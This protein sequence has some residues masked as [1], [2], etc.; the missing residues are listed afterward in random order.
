MLTII[1]HRTLASKLRRLPS[2]SRRRL[3]MSILQR[4]GRGYLRSPRPGGISRLRR[5]PPRLARRG[6]ACCCSLLRL[7]SWLWLCGK[8]SQ[9]TDSM[10][11]VCQIPTRLWT[12]PLSSGG[13]SS[14]ASFASS[15]AVMRASF[16]ATDSPLSVI[17]RYL[18]RADILSVK[19]VYR[20][21]WLWFWLI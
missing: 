13:L 1:F 20:L 19:K 15:C 2:V 5:L 21:C 18:L 14:R 11:S 6:P 12:N 8:A 9:H 16:C 3:R 4:L 7:S 10:V 17:F